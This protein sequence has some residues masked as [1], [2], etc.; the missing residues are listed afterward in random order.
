MRGIADPIYLLP[1]TL[2]VYVVVALKLGAVW[3]PGLPPVSRAA[4]PR[5]YWALVVLPPIG[6]TGVLALALTLH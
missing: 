4:H 6:V 1:F 2:G 3:L 5:G